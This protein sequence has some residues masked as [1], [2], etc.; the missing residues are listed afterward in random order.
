MFF[1]V[2]EA[3]QAHLGFSPFELV[4]GHTPRD[5]LKLLKEALLEED[6]P[7]CVLNRICDVRYKLL[8][9]N[10]FAT[11]NLKTAQSGMKARHDKKVRG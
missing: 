8:R 4:I 6:Q 3:I 5:L 7:E 11:E 2:R 10:N 1:P 9:A